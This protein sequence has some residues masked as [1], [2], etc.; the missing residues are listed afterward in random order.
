ML[1][2]KGFPG[3]EQLKVPTVKA[4]GV[5]LGG[6]TRS[7]EDLLSDAEDELELTPTAVIYTDGSHTPSPQLAAGWGYVVLNYSTRRSSLQHA[8]PLLES[9]GPVC[10]NHSHAD[11]MEAGALTNNTAELS[12][13]GQAF[14]WA[15]TSPL[16]A[17]V[18]AVQIRTDSDYCLGVLVGSS[19][20]TVN[21]HLIAVVRALLADL[22]ARH[23]AV[24]V[25]WIP[26]HQ[27]DLTK[28]TA[29]WNH[30]ADRLAAMG[31]L[32]A[33]LP[34]IRVALPPLPTFLAPLTSLT[35]QVH[36]RAP[37]AQQ[38]W[39][40]ARLPGAPQEGTVVAPA[41]IRGAPVINGTLHGAESLRPEMTHVATPEEA[42]AAIGSIPVADEPVH[43]LPDASLPAPLRALAVDGARATPRLEATPTPAAVPLTLQ[44]GVL[45]KRRRPEETQARSA[46]RRPETPAAPAR[47]EEPPEALEAIPRQG[48]ATLQEV[49]GVTPVPSPDR[50]LGKRR[51][52]EDGQDTS[53][54]VGS[55]GPS[56][57]GRE[58]LARAG[59][60]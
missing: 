46:R 51:R 57:P 36:L 15:L 13:I 5:F 16:M 50:V 32:Q 4:A 20:P 44:V 52:L 35:R 21:R 40:D 38:A 53:R 37:A 41:D 17:G 39:A 9:F 60:G 28:P 12:A 49:A 18:R 14:R 56:G 7:R 34:S 48:T 6:V 25:L 58:A 43:M 1:L 11:Y 8:I 26:S 47:E 29:F 45:G 55:G 22:R 54:H 2:T 30:R 24:S 33:P 31:R 23:L 27:T 19:R 3:A 42:P 10:L 59:V